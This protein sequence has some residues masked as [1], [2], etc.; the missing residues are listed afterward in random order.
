MNILTILKVILLVAIVIMGLAAAAGA[1]FPHNA[2]NDKD[3]S[4]LAGVS[5]SNFDTQNTFAHPGKDF[6]T[7]SSAILSIL[8][9]FSG[10][11]QPFYVSTTYTMICSALNQLARS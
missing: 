5:V 2:I 3:S 4:S 6:A 1:K 8:F 10:Y 11:Q 9:T 7:Y